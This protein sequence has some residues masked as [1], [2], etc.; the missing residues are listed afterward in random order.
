MVP[1]K[2]VHTKAVFLDP[3]ILRYKSFSVRGTLR[4]MNN[5]S[6]TYSWWRISLQC[7]LFSHLYKKVE[8]L[9]SR[10]LLFW[11][12]LFFAWIWTLL[13]SSMIICEFFL[14]DLLSS[15]LNISK[16]CNNVTKMS[17]TTVKLADPTTRRFIIWTTVSVITSTIN[18]F[19]QYIYRNLR[20]QQMSCG[21]H[22]HKSTV[23]T[24]VFSLCLTPT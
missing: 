24:G 3:C 5:D 18:K 17:Q 7:P 2:R 15:Q 10:K 6:E 12:E 19:N 21:A 20:T 14:W 11:F 23:I 1:S 4:L 9:I 13:L 16:T 8:T 22:A